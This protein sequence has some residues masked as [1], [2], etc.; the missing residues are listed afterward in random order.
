MQQFSAPAKI[1]MLGEHAVVYNQ[2]AIAVP[3]S[4]LRAYA[5]IMPNETDEPGLLITAQDLNQTFRF[6][7]HNPDNSLSF[8]VETILSNLGAKPPDA[9]IRLH[10]QIPLASGLGSGAAITTALTRALAAALNIAINHEQLNAIVYEVEK[11]YHGTPSGIDNT[12]VVYERPVF[13]VRDHPIERLTVHS[14][15]HFLIA[16]TGITAP[17]KTSV[18]DVRKLYEADP[19]TI[20]HILDSIGTLVRAGRSALEN[21]EVDKL[22]QHMN[23]NHELLQQLT[24][25]SDELDQL[26]TTARL[27]GASGAKLSG[28]GRGGNMIALVTENTVNAVHQS[29]LTAG[30]VRVLHTVLA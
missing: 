16:D 17:T 27:S 1:I 14:P 12:V 7:G 19:T 13:F 26:V 20:Q 5:S 29:L 24:V 10:S 4:E 28:G 30:A 6:T 21:G 11:Q 18:G 9:T 15:F 22:G 8:V 25:S 3:V 23:R 2:P